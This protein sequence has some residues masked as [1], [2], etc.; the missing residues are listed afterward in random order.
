MPS[1][2]KDVAS[3]ESEDIVLFGVNQGEAAKQVNSF[4]ERREW[5][6]NVVLD[7]KTKT[8]ELYQVKGIPHT[9]IIDRDGK[10]ANVF[11]GAGHNLKNAIE[12]IKTREQENS[13]Q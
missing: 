9:V 6:L 4:V 5:N 12:S 11:V 1:V 8:S 2:I 3:F 10:I 13:Q 7:E